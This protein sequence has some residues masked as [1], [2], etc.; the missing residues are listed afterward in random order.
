MLALYLY[1]FGKENYVNNP[2]KYNYL[3][4]YVRV[5]KVKVQLAC[6]GGTNSDKFENVL[7]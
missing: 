4:S 1:T 2:I 6:I 5:K 3:A 7:Y